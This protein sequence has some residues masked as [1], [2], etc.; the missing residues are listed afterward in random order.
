MNEISLN[1]IGIA[2]D[3]NNQIMILMNALDRMMILCPG[4]PDAAR[5]VRAAEHCA[6]LTSQLVPP[7]RPQALADR[8]SVKEVVSESAMLVRPLLPASNR[9]EVVCHTDC[10][11]AGPAAGI[12]QALVTLCI[13]ATE[14]MDGPGVI[15]IEAEHVDVAVI[16]SVRHTGAGAPAEF[17]DSLGFSLLRDAIKRSWGTLSVSDVF[18]QGTCFRIIL[19]AV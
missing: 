3:L 14:A 5:A 4:E 13:H 2:H 10:C 7:T 18:P 16:L 15:R 19:P 6:L 12:R 8:C 9:V 1:V 17:C 11:I